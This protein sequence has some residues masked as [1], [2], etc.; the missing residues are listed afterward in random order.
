M[1]KRRLAALT[2]PEVRSLVKGGR[3][4]LHADGGGLYLAIEGAGRARWAFR[5]MRRGRAREMGLGSIVSVS[6]AGARTA[7]AAAR[8]V[9]RQGGDPIDNRRADEATIVNDGR[10]FS[11]AAEAYI[12]AHSPAWRNAKH[13]A[14]WRATLDTYA[15]P[16]FGAIHVSEVATPNILQALQPIWL[17]KPETAARL[18]GRIEAVIDYA[19]AHGWRTGDN[20]AR[21]KGHLAS[22]LPRRAAVAPQR[23]HPALP[24]PRLPAF[25][26]ALG[27]HTG[28]AKL[29]LRLAILTAARTEEVLGATW[30]EFDLVNALWT[31]PAV[32]MK[33]GRA[34]RVPLSAPAVAVLDE[35]RQLRGI[36][37]DHAFPGF[38][39]GRPL[40]NMALLALT[41]RMNEPDADASP[42]AL[43]PWVDAD[44]RRVVPHG[45]RSTFRDWCEETTSTPHAVAE[46][47]L[48]HVVGDKTEAAYRRGD[49]FDKRR[50]L[51]EAWGRYA[52]SE[53]SDLPAP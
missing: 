23:H 1:P 26:I 52:T 16:V 32:R 49:L 48:A 20:P 53:I 4:A 46:A 28:V 10:S 14:Q 37:S 13:A 40:S 15:S 42:A 21:W 45:F 44:G 12:A 8:D 22:V 47:A 43:P 50:A 51:M 29:A 25:F 31:V 38:K 33:S 9:L 34:H 11:K 17:D 30:A 6:L 36:A 5:Y 2:A 35:A 27:A 41:R 3:S 7:A 24:W 19:T 39:R 18:R